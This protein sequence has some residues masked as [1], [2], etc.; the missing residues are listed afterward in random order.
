MYFRR[1]TQLKLLPWYIGGSLEYGNVWEDSSDISWDSGIAAGSLFLGADTPLGPF[2]LGYGH[3][4]QGRDAAF[5]Y[6]GKSF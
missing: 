6:L 3:A 2:Y 5:L 4:E 1:F